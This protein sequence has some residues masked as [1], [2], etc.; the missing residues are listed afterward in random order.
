MLAVFAF[1]L[2]LAIPPAHPSVGTMPTALELGDYDGKRRSIRLTVNGVEGLFALD[3]GG[4]ISLISPQFAQKIGC[5]PWG[6]HTGFR[7]TGERLDMPRC[8]NVTFKLSSG[9]ALQPVS[10]GVLDVRSLLWEGASPIDGSIALDAF[11]GRQFTLDLGNG[12]LT[13]ESP[14]S[15]TERIKAMTEVPMREVRQVSGHALGVAVPVPTPKGELWMTLDSGGGAPIL[16]R[17]KVAAEA[18]ADPKHEKLQPF[19]LK[20]GRTQVFETKAHAI[21]RDMILD[22]VIGLPVLVQWNMT[23]DLKD[24][25]LWLKRSR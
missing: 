22:G 1:A 12:V 4:G 25:R 8:E 6:V 10:A 20:V 16:L 23:F 7:L 14:A 11:E 19:N 24:D 2:A 18:G 13:L 5:K 17:D 9:D 3:T 21:V 15:L